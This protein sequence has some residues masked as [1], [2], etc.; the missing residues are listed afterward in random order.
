MI[1]QNEETDI[2]DGHYIE[3]LERTHIASSHLQMALGE[4]PVLLKHPDL[5]SLYNQSVEAL[6]ELYQAIGRLPETWK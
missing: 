1:N 2:N 3:L 6:E 5:N 4:H